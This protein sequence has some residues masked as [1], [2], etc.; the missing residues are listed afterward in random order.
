MRTAFKRN[1]IIVFA[2]A[3]AFSWAFDFA[4][5]DPALRTVIPFG[6]DPY[7]AVGSF[8]FIAGTLLAVVSLGRA[9]R[10]YR[11][12]RPTVA[13]EI[14]LLRTQLAVVLMVAVTVASDVVALAR[15]PGRWVGT[16]QRSELIALLIGLSALAGVVFLLLRATRNQLGVPRPRHGV[17]ATGTLLLAMLVLAFYPEQL[18]NG[19]ATHLLTVIVGDVVLF[20]SVRA[21]V[22]T[23]VPYEAADQPREVGPV[24]T[25]LATARRRWILVLIIGV[26]IG[27]FAFVGEMAEAGPPAPV[28]QLL[29]V[30]SVFVGLGAA[31][32]V[33]AYAF[34]GGPLGLG[35]LDARR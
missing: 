13:D 27:T 18:I 20:A 28:S 25:R 17:Q 33:V 34:L 16:P 30:A 7:D 24:Y 9:F 6:D 2:L 14:F 31:G 12:P 35:R 4:K 15:H 1:A 29:L 10:P 5:H 19:L 3:A 22:L 21:F 23:L 8:T 32:L 11:P 26:V